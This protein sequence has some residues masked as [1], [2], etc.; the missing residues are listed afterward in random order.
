MKAHNDNYGN[1]LADQLAKEAARGSE[2]EIA[3]NKIPK[4]A[5]IR[6]LKEEGDQGWQSEW[7]AS[8]KGVITKSFFPTIRDRLS[9]ILQMGIK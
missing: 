1:E 2:T 4:S 6:E 9:K 3:Y 8:T 5:V 7:D